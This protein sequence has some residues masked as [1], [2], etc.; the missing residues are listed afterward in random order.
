MSVK[1]VATNRKAKHDY[2]ILDTYEAGIV[3]RGSEIKSIRAGNISLKEAYVNIEDGREAWLISAHVAPYDRASHFN[4]DPNRPRKLLL[5]GSEIRRLWD[6]VRQKGVT[7]IPLRVYLKNGMAKVEI[8]MAKGKKL[9]DKRAAIAK[10]DAE[11]EI[12]RQLRQRGY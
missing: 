12:E 2:D 8:A 3:L 1:V 4:H 10:R 6:E 11:R 9:Y 5:H 7:I